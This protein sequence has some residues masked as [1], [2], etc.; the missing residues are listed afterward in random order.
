[1]ALAH[2]FFS[3]RVP[4]AEKPMAGIILA[5]LVAVSFLAG[6]VHFARRRKREFGQRPLVLATPGGRAFA[7][8]V[9]A[10]SDFRMGLELPRRK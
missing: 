3:R 7:A 5:A 8:N 4:R 2:M 9:G 1:M 10:L 6:V